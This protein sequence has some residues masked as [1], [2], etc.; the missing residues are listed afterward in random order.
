VTCSIPNKE[1]SMPVHANKRIT[2]P[3]PDST[4]GQP[5]PA[6]PDQQEFHQHLRALARYAMRILLEDVMRELAPALFDNMD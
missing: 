5:A 4:P 1:V 2:T 6:L 3:A